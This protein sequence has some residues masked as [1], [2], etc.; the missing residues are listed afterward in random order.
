MMKYPLNLRITSKEQLNEFKGK[1]LSIEFKN[2]RGHT[3]HQNVFT[4][5]EL[6]GAIIAKKLWKRIGNYVRLDNELFWY[7][8]ING[9]EDQQWSLVAPVNLKNDFLVLRTLTYEEYRTYHAIILKHKLLNEH[10]RV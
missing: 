3:I 6:K 2:G 1:P 9:D 8:T 7:E 10:K 4:Y 5:L